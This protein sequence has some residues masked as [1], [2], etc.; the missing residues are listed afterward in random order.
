MGYV[1]Y[2]KTSTMI[3]VTLR[4]KVYKTHGAAQAQIT[5][6]RKAAA[7]DSEFGALRSEEDPLYLY[8][9]ADEQYYRSNI[10]RIVTRKNLVSGAE[11]NES[12]NTPTY[13][14]PASDPYWEM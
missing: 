2:H 3:P 7:E 13:M 9:I 4:N 6:M 1:V 10:E 8:G 14:S 11:Y 5:R 12:I